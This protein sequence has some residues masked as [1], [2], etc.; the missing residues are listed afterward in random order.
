MCKKACAAIL[1]V[2]AL[3]WMM[4][5][6]AGLIVGSKAMGVRSGEFI[7]KDGYVVSTYNEGIEPVWQAAEAVL[8]DL[9]AYDIRKDR[10][11]AQGTITGFIAEEKVAITVEYKELDKTFVSILAG[12]GGS[13]IAGRLIHEKITQ[14]LSKA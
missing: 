8:K 10:K 7:Y 3:L 2:T 6:D 5:C 1:A 4:G 14:K 9:K 13:K 11:I 12:L